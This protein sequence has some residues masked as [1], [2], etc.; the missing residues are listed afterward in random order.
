MS[1][2]R[3][4]PRH[5]RQCGA[6]FLTSEHAIKQGKGFYCCHPCYGRSKSTPPEPRFWAMVEK[7]ET[8][9]NWTGAL[10]AGYGQIKVGHRMIGAHRYSWELHHGD[11]P[12]GL[13]VL[14]RCDN[15]RCVRPDH[16]F[17]GTNSDNI[18]DAHAKGRVPAAAIEAFRA[19]RALHAQGS[20]N[21]RAKLTEEQ[22]RDIRIRYAAG[23]T[24]QERLAAQYRVDESLISL[25]TRR[26][27][28]KHV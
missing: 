23:G 9:W 14:H 27:V 10:G 13:W 20:A 24:T 3:S 6:P 21:P 15:P 28:W 1:H 17:L 5:C 22:A 11:I 26:K 4:I 12:K 8:C 25:I 19:N 16:L 2:K 7:T 18:L